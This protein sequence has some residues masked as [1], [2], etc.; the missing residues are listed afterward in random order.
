MTERSRVHIADR[1]VTAP[2]ERRQAVLEVIAAARSR[3]VLSLFRCTDK[4]VF[5]ELARAAERGVSVEVLVT[6]RAKDQ[7]KLR[8]LWERLEQTGVSVHPHLDPVVKYHAKYLVV[9]DGPAVVSSLNFT[10]KSFKRTID[11][12][13][14]T[15]DEGVVN[16]L[17]RL[18]MADR[19]GA[20]LPHDLSPRL[21]VGPEHAR[22]QL[23][24]IIRQAQ[25]SIHLLDAKLSDPAL[26]ALLEAR[27]AEGLSI[28]LYTAKRFG[29]L[30]AH[31]KIMLVDGRLAVV[32][33]LAL[34]ALSL[35]FRRE[36]AVIVE[37][38]TAVGQIVGLFA[39]LAE[40]GSVV[41]TPVPLTQ[42]GTPC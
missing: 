22:E 2:A 29:D 40:N 20:R 17:S 11:A 8:R 25:S 32:G 41:Q 16:S 37:E 27:R 35:D 13:V 9:D 23:T 3:I 30:R 5:A 10:R 6:S 14:V 19:E 34:A 15:Y 36:V 42:G 26:V 31:G 12:L 38:P 39:T 1:V 33:S 18:M 24:A 7:K 28:E 4:S 21:I